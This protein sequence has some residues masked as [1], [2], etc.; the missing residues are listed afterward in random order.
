MGYFKLWSSQWR[1]W[2]YSQG[3][4]KYILSLSLISGNMGLGRRTWDLTS[5]ALDEAGHSQCRK[6]RTLDYWFLDLLPVHTTFQ[7]VPSSL[8]IDHFRCECLWLAGLS[9]FPHCAHMKI[10]NVPLCFSSWD[11]MVTWRSVSR[12][13]YPTSSHRRPIFLLTQMPRKP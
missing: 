3:I 10:G 2:L 13:Y 9:R 11:L 12:F 7:T 8:C 6:R 5:T 1:T 4:C